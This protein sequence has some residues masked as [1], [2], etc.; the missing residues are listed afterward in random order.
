MIALFLVASL[1]FPGMGFMSGSAA[2]N[3]D[4]LAATTKTVQNGLASNKPTEADNPG[5]PAQKL[6]AFRFD[7]MGEDKLK[8]Y[9]VADLFL[10]PVPGV[11]SR[12]MPEL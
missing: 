10:P 6:T 5:D 11:A 12:G 9:A 8:Q 2:S 1:F 7:V 4:V 3:A